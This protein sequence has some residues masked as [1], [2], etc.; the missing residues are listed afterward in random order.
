MNSVENIR[1]DEM[2]MFT[3][4]IRLVNHGLHYSSSGINEPEN[5]QEKHDQLNHQP[6]Q[7]SHVTD[8]K[9]LALVALAVL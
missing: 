2:K 4:S 3:C 8:I 6:S 5:T 1:E 7:T 9:H